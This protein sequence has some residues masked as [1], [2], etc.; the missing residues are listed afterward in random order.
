MK[1]CLIYLGVFFRIFKSISIHF[2]KAYL[3]KACFHVFYFRDIP[4]IVGQYR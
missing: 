1:W 4:K 2:K 3:D